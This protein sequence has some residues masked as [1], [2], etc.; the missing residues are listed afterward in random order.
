MEKR[1]K[2]ILQ[3][4]ISYNKNNKQLNASLLKKPLKDILKD[5][6]PR[7]LKIKDYEFEF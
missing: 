1:L 4:N 3:C 5:K 7:K 6:I 2:P